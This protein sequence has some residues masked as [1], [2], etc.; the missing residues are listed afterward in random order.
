MG[1]CRLGVVFSVSA[2]V[3][4]AISQADPD[5]CA[6][7]TSAQVSAAV[8]VPVTDGKHV[9]PTYM[10]TCTWTASGDFPV[11]FVTLYLQTTTAY[12][13]GKQMAA[14]MAAASS[15]SA[16]KPASVGDDSY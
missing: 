8:G 13:G 4:P 10:K 6:L 11:K 7:L 9:S 12:D 5:A 15:G 16:V 3:L 2:I 14:S 1:T